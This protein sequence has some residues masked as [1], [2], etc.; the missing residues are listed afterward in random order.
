MKT[1][2][3][4]VLFGGLLSLRLMAQDNPKLEVFGGYQY[5]HIGLYSAEPFNAGAFNG[6]NAAAA[7]NLSKYFG[8]E[9]DFGGAYNYLT[10]SRASLKIYTYSGGPVVYMNRGR[11]KLFAHALVGGIHLTGSESGAPSISQNGY[12]VMAGG[13]VDTKVHR[14]IA[15]RLVQADWLYYNLSSTTVQGATIAGFSHSNNVRIS[16]GVVLRF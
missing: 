15:I 10:I 6:W 4:W 16:T 13:G 7:A 8:V 2:F 14:A 3:V 12:T 1:F 5:L 11:I 9:G